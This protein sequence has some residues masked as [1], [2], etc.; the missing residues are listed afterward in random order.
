MTF[1]VLAVQAVRA[2]SQDMKHVL[3]I[4]SYH[5]G[6]AWTDGQ[7][8]GIR[9]AFSDIGG[10]ELVSEYMD[11]KR[12]PYETVAPVFADYLER[13]W[14]NHPFDA[15]IVTDNNALDFVA[16]RYERLFSGIPVFFC[17]INN[18]TPEMLKPFNGQATGVVQALNPGKNIDVIQ[19]LQPRLRRLVVVAGT[20]PTAKAIVNEVR[21]ILDKEFR[22]FECVWLCELDTS[23]L[24]E[25]LG[26][27]GPEDAVLL[28]NFNRDAN[29]I[30]YSH[31]EGA[32]IIVQH[33]AAPVYAMEDNYLGTGIVGGYMTAS[34]DQGRVAAELCIEALG[35]G[36]TPDVVLS[37]PNVYMFDYEAMARFN[38]PDSALPASAIILNEPV[39]F[40]HQ[41]KRM[42]WNAVILFVLLLG[43]FLGVSYGLLRSRWAEAKMRESHSC[44]K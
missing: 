28:C 38:L 25:E 13:K 42:I 37:S 2:G 34:H 9:H 23:A 39:S 17:G 36:R 5:E 12:I 3:I 16:V 10:F 18:F 31:E 1:L 6:L 35:S 29:G 8:D 20:T 24:K 44:P 21:G 32:R 26:K 40:Y 14:K 19:A 11:S 30:Y 43:A 7:N 33:S 15:V 27:I 22:P 4:H 41:Y